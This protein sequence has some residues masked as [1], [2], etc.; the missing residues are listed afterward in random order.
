MAVAD[1]IVIGAGVVGLATALKLK[2]IFP[3]KKV[4]VLE[5][6]GRPFAEASRFNSG[7]IHSGIHQKPEFLKSKLA[8]RGGP[9]LIDFCKKAEVPFRKSGMLIAVASE[10]LLGLW[11][12]AKLL[13][14]LYKNSRQ[15]KIPLQFLTGRQ[16]KRLEPNVRAAFGL[17]L[18]EIFVVDQIEL[19]RKLLEAAKE[20]GAEFVFNAEISAIRRRRKT[21]EL[22]FD[23]QS[24]G[25]ETVVNSAGINADR[26]AGLAG[27][28]KY[29]IFP[30]RG[31]YYEAIGG[32]S[33]LIRSVLVYPALRPGHPVKGIHLTK[34]ADGRLLVGPN[35]SSWLK[36]EDDFSVRTPP[37]EFLKAA[38]KFLPDLGIGDLRWAYS[39]LRAKI[40]PGVGEDDFVIK[41]EARNPTFINLVGIESPGLTASFA[42]AEEVARL[43][44]DVA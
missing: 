22:V 36:K 11:S 43:I 31:E 4:V 17:Y 9:M 8:R 39:G 2:T 37:K 42:I 41:C 29:N 18:P 16:I 10:D 32:K 20:R 3:D 23:K 40:N 27:F 1:I 15:Q 30:Y 5:K 25:A 34:T 7:V 24:L 28:K 33:E 12:E 14:L 26:I 21:Y 19:G 6:N 35:V 44:D 13:R 38:G